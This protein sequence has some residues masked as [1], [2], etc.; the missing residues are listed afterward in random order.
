MHHELTSAEKKEL[1]RLVASGGKILAVKRYR[2]ITGVGL[3][4]AMHAVEHLGLA[5]TTSETSG[6]AY[7]AVPLL[8]PGALRQAEAAAMA[9]L[10]EGNAI[11]AIKRYR[12]YT[13]VGLKEAKEAID[14]LGVVHRSDGRIDPKLARA[15]IAEVAA[16]RKEEAVIRLITS[17]G[18]DESEARAIVAKLGSMRIGG[19]SCGAGCLRMIVAFIVIILVFV[20]LA[21]LLPEVLKS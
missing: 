19:Q 15:L 6:S 3:Q 11:E 2:E 4:E 7:R 5:P 14:A 12:G 8:D 9:A 17:K 21:V 13:N 10:R 18:Y 20:A 16:G 1:Q